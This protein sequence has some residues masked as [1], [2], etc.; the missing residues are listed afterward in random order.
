MRLPFKEAT[1]A[2]APSSNHPSENSRLADAWEPIWSPSV[3]DSCRNQATDALGGGIS[4]FGHR[5][6]TTHLRWN[7]DPVTGYEWPSIPAHQIDYRH[8]EG[9][10]PKWVWEINRLLFLV[11]VAFAIESAM[12]ERQKGEEFLSSVLHRWITETRVGHGPQWSASIEVAIRSI[13]MTLAFETLKSPD[14]SLVEAMGRSIRAHSDWIKRFPSAFSSA[15]NHRVAELAALLLLDASWSDILNEQ[16]T[17]QFEQELSTVS[18]LLFSRDGL[19]LEQSPTYAG[20]SLEFLALTLR[21]RRWRDERSLSRVQSIVS[22][23]A[24]AI[25]Q[26]SDENGHLMRYGDDDE[27]KIVTVVASRDDYSKALVKLA[28]DDVV[29]RRRGLL[30][31]AA[32]GL[33][34]LRFTDLGSETTWLFDH[35]PLGF[36]E[37][38]AHGHADTLSVSMRSDGVDWIVDAGT[39]RYHGDREWRTYFRS[40]RAHNAP[41]IAN[42]DS[43][44]M[45]G[46]FNWDPRKRAVA[47]LVSSHTDGDSASIS[48]THDGY[49]RQ[50]LAEVTRTVHR[51]AEGR[52][53]ITDS[54]RTSE[55]MSTGF[56]INPACDIER[57]N[58]SFLI[59]H[60]DSALILGLRVSGYSECELEKPE[61]ES[62]WF[63]PEFGVKMPTWRVCAIAR[64]SDDEQ[65]KQLTFEIELSMKSSREAIK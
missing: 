25:T 2:S 42:R 46:D 64:P 44:V 57:E 51:I 54:C 10:D 3:S 12:I 32:G 52:Y 49:A 19:G 33:S 1:N 13:A 29:C 23:A 39:Y 20:F 38:A 35:G 11:P 4:I 50:G 62:A 24:V 15:N 59:T 47:T 9:A 21:C 18:G 8:S 58:D 40:S 22:E 63:S 5:W 14:P 26:L 61:H 60:P 6:S 31:F 55:K 27:G 43:S 17:V 45:T 34:L 36:G 65:N 37:I 7:N 30:T 28:V 53:Q 41:Q 48:A 16:E 56:M